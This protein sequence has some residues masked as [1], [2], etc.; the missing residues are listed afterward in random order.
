MDSTAPLV[1]RGRACMPNGKGTREEGVLSDVVHELLYCQ[2]LESELL[3][4]S[5]PDVHDDRPPATQ[6][7]SRC[8]P[9]QAGLSGARGQ[10]LLLF[11][12][13]ILYYAERQHKNHSSKE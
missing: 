3:W 9:P 10:G 12:I 2:A 7:T 13:I 6:H 4:A 5:N 1:G 8:R 11:F